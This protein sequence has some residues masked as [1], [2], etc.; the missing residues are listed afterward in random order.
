MTTVEVRL[1]RSSDW[2]DWY[3]DFVARAETSKILKYVDVDKDG[4][5]LDEP[6]PPLASSE[7]LHKLNKDA[8]EAWEQERQQNAEGAG[9]KPDTISDLSEK[10]WTQLTRLQAEYKVQ[11]VTYATYQKAYAD[12]AAWVRSTVDRSYLNN[13]SSKSNLRVIV[14]GLRAKAEDWL[15]AWNKAKLEGERRKIPELKGDSTINDFLT[16][17]A[18]FDSAW[19]KQYRSLVASNRKTQNKDGYT[20][21]QLAELFAEEVRS[22]RAANNRTVSSQP[23]RTAL[24]PALAHVA[25][26]RYRVKRGRIKHCKESLKQAKWKS[27]VDTV[28][29]SANSEKA[30]QPADRE[31]LRKYGNFVGLTLSAE[32]LS[33]GTTDS[34]FAALNQQHPLYNSTILDGGATTHVVNCEDLLGD[35]REAPEADYVMIGDSSLKTK[36]VRIKGPTTIQCKACSQGKAHEIISRRESANRA[37]QPFYRVFADL[38]E[39]PAAYNGHR[40]ILLITDEFSGMMF[41]WSLSS[42][43]ETGRNIMEFEARIKRHTGASICKIRVDNERSVINLPHQTISEFQ[44]WATETKE[45]LDDSRET[46]DRWF[47]QHFRW[48]RPPK[49]DFDST[50]DHRPDWSGIYAFGCRAYPLNPRYKAG[51]DIKL[52]KLSPRAHV[53]YLVGYQ[54]SNLYRI[55]VPK[56]NRV[57]LSRDVRFNE[58]EFFDPTKEDELETTPV[59]EYRP[60]SK[61]LEPLPQQ[62]CDS[63]LTEFLYEFDENVLGISPEVSDSCAGPRRDELKS[64]KFAA[65][66][67]RFTISNKERFTISNKE[68]FELA[69][70]K[71]CYAEHDE[72]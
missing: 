61:S 62:D 55:W 32:T 15:V 22:T 48:Y 49:V 65:P 53:G 13:A 6:M 7:M 72:H 28:K 38:F 12:L 11:M 67:E 35:I 10:Q 24:W 14:R 20:L 2:M 34:V 69:I 26:P 1:T 39:F 44:N 41:S 4:P 17:V 30:S 45:R 58:E 19:S 59:I 54:A 31:D 68:R 37:R 25:Y 42:K 57:I 27:L 21:R 43:T 64:I 56:L 66:K 63:I 50:K 5:E 36:G 70:E 51:H 46:I 60:T 8:F 52:F 40:Y 29:E 47:H 9:P 16:A 3:E 23:L 33:D 71:Q 18:A